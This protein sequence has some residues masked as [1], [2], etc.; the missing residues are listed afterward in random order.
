MDITNSSIAADDLISSLRAELAAERNRNSQSE[1]L[2][3]EIETLRTASEA[4]KAE[5]K[6]LQASLNEAKNEVKTLQAKLVA[7]RS[8]SVEAATSRVPGSAIKSNGPRTIM[9]GAAEGAKE[10]QKRH[11]KE[12]LYRDLTGMLIMDVKRRET[13]DGE[14]DVFDCIQTGR[15]GCKCP[16]RSVH[17]SSS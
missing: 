15:N 16:A 14:E 8:S 2:R 5:K 17:R 7:A 10:A 12:E 11:L 1:K 3:S 13:D 6:I 4:H 9:V